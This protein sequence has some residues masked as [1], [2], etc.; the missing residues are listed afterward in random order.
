ML[1]VHEDQLLVLLLMVKAELDQRRRFSPGDGVQ[2]GDELR[3]RCVDMGAISPDLGDAGA[4]DEAALGPR[5]ARAHRLVIGIEEIGVS[6][7]E[8]AIAG[9]VRR[10]QEGLEEPAGMGAMPLG[11]ADIGHRLDRLVFGRERFSEGVGAPARL[12]IAPGERR[13]V[14]VGCRDIPRNR[15]HPSL[16]VPSAPWTMNGASPAKLPNPA[17]A[18]LSSFPAHPARFCQ[19]RWASIRRSAHPGESSVPSC[20]REVIDW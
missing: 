13:T 17:L 14:A 5:M 8:N 12:G 3:H 1:D 20:S 16:P 7:I 10:Q 6:R 18:E 2:G 15:P 4:R 9:E 19:Q 11:R